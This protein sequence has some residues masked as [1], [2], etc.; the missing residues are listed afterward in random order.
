MVLGVE[1]LVLPMTS[2]F[3][4]GLGFGRLGFAKE[5]LVCHWS[6]AWESWFNGKLFFSM[7]WGLEGLGLLRKFCFFIGFGCG[8]L[9]F[10][11]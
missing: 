6:W 8:K 3:F 7:V 10:S 4:N 9:F 2:C 11:K 5:M 1:N